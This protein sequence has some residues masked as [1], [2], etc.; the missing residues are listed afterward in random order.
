M[1]DEEDLD[2]AD[3][4]AAL[5]KSTAWFYITDEEGG[6]YTVLSQFGA[7]ISLSSSWSSPGS[8]LSK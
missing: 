4:L 1:E 7:L 8:L 6:T 3:L 5:V 2:Y